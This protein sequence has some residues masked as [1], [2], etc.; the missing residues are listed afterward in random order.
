MIEISSISLNKNPSLCKRRLFSVFKIT[1]TCN[2]TVKQLLYLAIRL[3]PLLFEPTFPSTII[4]MPRR[5]PPLEILDLRRRTTLYIFLSLLSS[6]LI[7]F[8]QHLFMPPLGFLFR[9]HLQKLLW[10][11]HL[12]LLVLISFG[13]LSEETHL[14]S[15]YVVQQGLERVRV[16]VVLCPDLLECVL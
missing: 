15:S 7:L 1:F 3:L 16:C 6:L 4:T 2:K 10:I 14:A 11:R 5:S 13:L 8:N 12:L 9:E